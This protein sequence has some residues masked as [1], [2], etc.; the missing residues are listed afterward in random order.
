MGTLTATGEGIAKLLAS[1]PDMVEM[2]KASDMPTTRND[3]GAYMAKLTQVADML[4]GIND[5]LSGEA[6]LRI[7]ARAMTLAGGNAHGIA[8]ALAICLG[9]PLPNPADVM[10]AG[11]R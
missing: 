1:D 7:A 8:D 4:G 2:A 6:G 9:E 10:L 3:Y 11:G 5:N